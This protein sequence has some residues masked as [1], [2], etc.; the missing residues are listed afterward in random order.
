MKIIASILIILAGPCALWAADL[1]VFA[2][3]S[4]TE[5]LTDIAGQYQRTTGDRITFNFAASSLLARQIAEG[6]PADLFFS[7]DEEKMDGLQKKGLIVNETRKS[8][9]SNTLVIVIPFDSRATVESPQKLAQSNW[10]IALAEPKTVPAGIYAKAYLQKIG[11]WTNVIDRLIPTENVRAALAAVESG[12]VDA[13][14]VYKTDAGIS[15]RVKIAYEVP[16]AEGPKISYPLAV[17]RDSKNME[18][19]KRLAAYL[20][21]TEALS[22]FKRYGFLVP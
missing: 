18:A 6:A 16:I 7:A 15:T 17:L 12:N 10:K 11:I 9:L 21:S 19:A 22:V 13:G 14:I 1:Q 2:A 5:V 3:A 4:L 20:A 8:L